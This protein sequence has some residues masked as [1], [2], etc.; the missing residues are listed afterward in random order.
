MDRKSRNSSLIFS[1]PDTPP[2]RK[3]DDRH[4]KPIEEHLNVVGR[5]SNIAEL[6]PA[7]GRTPNLVI[8]NIK[9]GKNE[10]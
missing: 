9:S 7:I 5:P 10:S 4:S 2:R 3:H 6:L 8:N 1:K